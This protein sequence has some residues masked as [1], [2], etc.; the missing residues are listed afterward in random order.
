MILLLKKGCEIVMF[1]D[2]SIP[3]K[4]EL[5]CLNYDIS[6]YCKFL[7]DCLHDTFP[8]YLRL[9]KSKIYSYANNID[10]YK[11]NEFPLKYRV[12]IIDYRLNIIFA[13]L[14]TSGK[15]STFFSKYGKYSHDIEDYYFGDGEKLEEKIS[16]FI[17]YNSKGLKKFSESYGF[18]PV[19]E[20]S[21][22]TILICADEEIQEHRLIS[23]FQ[24]MI[25]LEKYRTKNEIDWKQII[26]RINKEYEWI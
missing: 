19:E 1:F 8:D 24:T 2:S 22:S 11:P 10:K 20:L 25:L 4:H 26:N 13:G 16:G 5:N 6:L 9:Y 17:N 23:T 18:I 12:Y 21:M 3:L 7:I 15:M 14:D